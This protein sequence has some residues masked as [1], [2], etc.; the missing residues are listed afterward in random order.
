MIKGRKH[1]S[2][3]LI[4]AIILWTAGLFINII[5]SQVLK[6]ELFEEAC[7][8]ILPEKVFVHFSESSVIAGTDLEYAA[9]F[10]SPIDH[11][12]NQTS[13]IIY[14]EIVN[15]N[16]KLVCHW[17]SN[18]SNRLSAGNVHIP[19]SLSSGI[20]IA[21]AYTHWMLNNGPGYFYQAPILIQNLKDENI[22]Y[23]NA[24]KHKNFESQNEQP[25]SSQVDFDVQLIENKLKVKIISAAGNLVGQNLQL[26]GLIQDK[27]VLE[28]SINAISNTFESEFEFSVAHGGIA[29]IL[30]MNRYKEVLA[31]KNI[32]IKKLAEPIIKLAG[33]K[34]IY[35]TSEQVNIA[36]SSNYLDPGEQLYYSCSIRE[37]G[38]VLSDFKAAQIEEYLRYYSEISAINWYDNQAAYSSGKPMNDHSSGLNSWLWS[39]YYFSGTNCNFFKEYHSF[40]LEGKVSSTANESL[41]N[42]K[43]YLSHAADHPV[44]EYAITNEKGEFYFWLNKEFDNKNLILQAIEA[45]TTNSVNWLLKPQNTMYEES[46][47]RSVL[48]LTEEQTEI[49]NETA[50]VELINQVYKETGNP[51][52]GSNVA[53]RVLNFVPDY[54]VRPDDYS[55]LKNFE[56]VA[57]NILP[58]VFFKKRKGQWT[59]NIYNNLY[60]GNLVKGSTIFLNGVPYY[61]WEYIAQIPKETIERVEVYSSNYF[62]GKINFT[63]IVAIYTKKRDLPKSYLQNGI[64]TFNNEVIEY[65]NDEMVHKKVEDRTS[66]DFKRQMYWNPALVLENGE[67]FNL[68]FYTSKLK[69]TYIVDIQGITNKG[70]PVSFQ[71]EFIVE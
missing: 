56:E 58:G 69:T 67:E 36:I 29:Q 8:D 54:I 33:Q 19:D 68:S 59:L 65:N 17:R 37:K 20:Y 57:N 1:I 27:K 12:T 4:A 52:A 3:K 53:R 66:P 64:K 30:L 49:L 40:L 32:Y 7:H 39:N 43:I 47:K 45:D 46:F 28:T 24:V 70:R 13:S 35:S 15:W 18:F 50:N 22:K 44:V 34:S 60:S 42:T 26:I 63:G 10:I 14:F 51:N 71:Y 6:Y 48:S 41:M 38:T 62:Y 5:Y 31:S 21:R 11:S 9:Y 55:D 61:D 16:N 25:R 23:L 2:Q